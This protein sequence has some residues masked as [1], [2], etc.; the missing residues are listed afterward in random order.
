[1]P[2]CGG[3]RRGR[4]GHENGMYP[5]RGKGGICDPSLPW[6]YDS[7]ACPECGHREPRVQGVPCALRQCPECGCGL[8][9]K[10][11]RRK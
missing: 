4:K 7:C 1:M 5:G 10:H 6:P 8:I 11:E 3:Y 9:R 2:G